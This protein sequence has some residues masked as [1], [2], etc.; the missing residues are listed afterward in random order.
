MYYT[1]LCR[2]N[3]ALLFD[4]QS[5]MEFYHEIKKE[6]N[7][8]QPRISLTYRKINTYANESNTV[9]IGQG[10]PYSIQEYIQSLNVDTCNTDTNTDTNTNISSKN[11]LPVIERNNTNIFQSFSTEN[12]SD[13]FNWNEVYGQGYNCL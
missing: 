7:V 11:R 6:M 13:E 2:D 10:S 1:A 5:N 12:K 8:T 9:I 4:L 3:T